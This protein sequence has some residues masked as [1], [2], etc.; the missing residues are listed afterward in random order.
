L[1]LGAEEL[2]KAIGSIEIKVDR[3]TSRLPEGQDISKS[4]CDPN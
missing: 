1:F 4:L 3:S 2:V